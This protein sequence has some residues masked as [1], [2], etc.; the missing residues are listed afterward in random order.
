MLAIGVADMPTGGEGRN[1]DHGNARARA[2]E[3]DRLD[4]ARVIEAAALVRGDEDR[5]LL[6][7]LLVAL[8]E[9]DDVLGKGLEQRPLGRSGVAVHGIVRLRIGNRRERAVYEI[10]V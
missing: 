6:P 4:E 9:L 2:E 8:R 1:G 7:L 3:I 10:G 5:C